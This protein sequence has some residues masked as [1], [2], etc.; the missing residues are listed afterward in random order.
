LR[1]L[2]TTLTLLACSVGLQAAPVTF[3]Q[4]LGGGQ[5]YNFSNNG[6]D[7]AT[8]TATAQVLFAIDPIVNVPLELQLNNA[9]LTIS[10]TTSSSATVNGS[11]VVQSGVSGTITVTRNTPF[12][13]FTNLLT[14]LFTNGTFSGELGGTSITLNASTPPL[15]QVTFT[16][17]FFIFSP[18]TTARA[19]ALSFSSVTP[20]LSIAADGQLSSFAASGTGTFSAEPVPTVVPEPGVMSLLGGGLGL[21]ALARLRR[22]SN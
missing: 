19:F 3:G 6:V 20:A 14:V 13:G 17:D 10:A 5:A 18:D 12:N 2:V 15:N 8:F 1:T 16:S 4:F 11:Q 22:R 9:T 7:P 21:I